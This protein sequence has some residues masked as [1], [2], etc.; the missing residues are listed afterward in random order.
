MFLPSLGTDNQDLSTEEI[1]VCYGGFG[2]EILRGGGG[3][4]F[5]LVFFFF[6]FFFFFALPQ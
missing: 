4:C 2:F 1:L 5:W 6:F 3:R